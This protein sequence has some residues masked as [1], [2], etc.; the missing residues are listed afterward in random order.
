MENKTKRTRKRKNNM[1]VKTSQNIDIYTFRDNKIKKEITK[2]CWGC[3][4][5]LILHLHHILSNGRIAI[6]TKN[7]KNIAQKVCVKKEK[8]N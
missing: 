6:Q 8:S 7:T 5:Q 2:P 3:S 4:K 1:L